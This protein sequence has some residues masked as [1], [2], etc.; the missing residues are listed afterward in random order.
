LKTK[1]SFVYSYIETRQ[2]CV[3]NK[4]PLGDDPWGYD[5]Y[6]N[7]S[8]NYFRDKR[9]PEAQQSRPVR[10][11]GTSADMMSFTGIGS[12]EFWS[13]GIGFDDW[14]GSF[15]SQSY[16]DAV[17]AGFDS[18]G[19]DFFTYDD[20][21]N[22]I[23]IEQRN[24]QL[25]IPITVTSTVYYEEDGVERVT[26]KKQEYITYE[27]AINGGLLIGF[28]QDT[29]NTDLFQMASDAAYEINKWNPLAILVNSIN[30]Y[31]TG[32]DFERGNPMS[33][34]EATFNLATM[35]PA[36]R[37]GKMSFKIGKQSF[38]YLDDLFTKTDI[39]HSFPQSFDRHIIKNG[40]WSQRIKD[41][42]N[43]YQM[44]GLINGKKGIYQIGV[45]KNGVIFHRN[46][47]PF[48]N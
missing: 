46:F 39:Y 44:E 13:D 36:L 14:N 29:D 31:F 10:M 7:S 15:G 33:I 6:G 28:N 12:G 45:N 2:N 21:G 40:A 8:M 4:D 48:K 32:V 17:N 24:G 26:G 5:G 34:E 1:L 23:T 42:A 37:V 35:V 43:W 41:G 19:R 22:R 11:F 16:R 27:E 30:A 3:S 20:E 9:R 47:L 18:W 25:L 38:T